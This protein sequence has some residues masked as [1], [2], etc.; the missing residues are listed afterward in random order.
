MD[1]KFEVER[2]QVDHKIQQKSSIREMRNLRDNHETLIREVREKA[3]IA[4]D[5]V[6]ALAAK[7][8]NL[9]FVEEERFDEHKER[10]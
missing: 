8:R 1:K 4:K 3:I 7:F 5:E 6:D 10:I 2:D 9:K